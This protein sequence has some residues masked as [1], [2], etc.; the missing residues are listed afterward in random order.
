VVRFASTVAGSYRDSALR[1]YPYVYAAPG[2]KY[3]C[4]TLAVV[5]DGPV[6]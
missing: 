2:L 4:P 6:R 1:G 5:V 3:P